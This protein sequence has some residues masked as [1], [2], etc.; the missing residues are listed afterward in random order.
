[1]TSY[2]QAPGSGQLSLYLPH[3]HFNTEPHYSNRV[4]MST[5]WSHSSDSGAYCH[6]TQVSLGVYALVSSHIS[7]EQMES[8]WGPDELLFV[9]AHQWDVHA[10]IH[11]STITAGIKLPQ[12]RPHF[13][14]SKDKT[15]P[16]DHFKSWSHKTLY[17]KVLSFCFYV[18][19]SWALW[20]MGKIYRHLPKGQKEQES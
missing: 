11:K 6:I 19:K 2:T 13:P 17:Q 20:R 5:L 18:F 10:T 9:N 15:M 7:G 14:P 16:T 1:M 3:T 12:V 4:A 8:S